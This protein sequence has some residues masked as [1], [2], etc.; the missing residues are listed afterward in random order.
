MRHP[1]Q[2][3]F[4]NAIHDNPDDDTPRLVYADWLEEH[5]E[6][7]RAEFIRVGVELARVPGS[8][9]CWPGTGWPCGWCGATEKL[10]RRQRELLAANGSAWFDTALGWKNT[11]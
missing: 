2:V 10:R 7:D 9:S 3:A 11:N 5:G 6:P 1:D 4:L 8:C